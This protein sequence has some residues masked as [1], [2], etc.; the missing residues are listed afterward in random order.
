MTSAAVEEGILT[1]REQMFYLFSRASLDIRALCLPISCKSKK[2]FWLQLNLL[3]IPRS[4]IFPQ[5]T[6]CSAFKTNL[7]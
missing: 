3:G 2:P 7:C 6:E 5:H 1:S 4:V